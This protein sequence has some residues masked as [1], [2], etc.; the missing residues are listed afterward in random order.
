MNEQTIE[1]N[2]EP[3]G[4]NLMPASIDEA[5]FNALLDA[6]HPMMR[7]MGEEF[8]KLGAL[9]IV[10]YE[11]KPVTTGNI[12]VRVRSAGLEG[13]LITGS[14]VDKQHL[15]REDIVFVE[16]V[17]HEKAAIY[18]AGPRRPSKEVLINNEVYREFPDA[19]VVA[20]IHDSLAT[21]HADV[22]TSDYKIV[23]A[24]LQQARQVIP[25]LRESPYVALQEHGQVI[26]GRDAEDVLNLARRY[27][28]RTGE[29]K[30]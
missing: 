6:Y 20:H 29:D 19:N 12:S 24:N 7:M 4:Y 23:S 28:R 1:I 25:L 5:T 2:R 13:F 21:G 22:P 16:R 26:M 9:P 3:T 17:D 18:V 30:C 8:A 15:K 11:G 10:V 27:H 14:N